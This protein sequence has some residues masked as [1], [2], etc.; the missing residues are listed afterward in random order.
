[1]TPG[2][3]R[4]N[5]ERDARI[6]E[7]AAKLPYAAVGERFGMTAK[8]IAAIVHRLKKRQAADLVAATEAARMFA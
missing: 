7:L 5:V 6:L 8:R 4:I 2:R 1:M 3:P